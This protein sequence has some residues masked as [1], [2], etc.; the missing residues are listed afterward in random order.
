MKLRNCLFL[1]FLAVALGAAAKAP[2]YIFL[3]IG[4]GMGMGPVMAAQNYNRNVLHND[5]PLNMMQFPVVGWAQTWSASSDITDSA[6]AGTA[7]ST[8]H[9]TR[10]YMLG[11]N[12]DTVAVT[13]VAKIL[14]DKGFG[15]AVATSVAPDDATPGAFYTH[16]PNRSMFYEIGRDMAECGYEFVAGA[17]LR[18]TMTDGKPND[19]LDRF[20]AA[21][22]QIVRGPEGTKEMASE[23]VLLLGPEGSSEHNIGYTIDSIAGALTLPMITEAALTQLE[24]TSPRKFFMMV[25]GGNIDHALHGNDAGAS[26]KE[27][28]NFDQAIGLAFDFYRAHPDETLIIV[29]ADHDTGGMAIVK[30]RGGKG[31]LANIDCQKVSKE[32]FSNYCKAMLKSRNIYKWEDMKEYLA[33]NLGFFSRIPVSE[34][35][36]AKLRK[37]FDDTFEQ[38]NTADQKTL[39]A[40]FNAFAVAVFDMFNE[41]AGV[42]FC[43]TSHSGNVVP[44]FAIGP[45]SDALKGFNNNI[46]IP[47]AILRAVGLGK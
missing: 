13:S 46:D 14:H 6:A 30:Q 2:K 1:L 35:A 17:G 36:E 18:G 28:L 5:K 4:D 34:K 27:I 38:R 15:V 40:N 23:R 32:E 39:Y 21:G 31:G 20:A 33:D 12:A 8:G 10:N 3:Y 22:V 44:V 41:A 45:G 7:L 25:E 11:M 24:R 42:A 47:A 9:K 19:L 16:V 37:L 43:T 29:T 26:I